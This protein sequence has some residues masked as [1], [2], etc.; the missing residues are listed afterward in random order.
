VFSSPFI[1]FYR[2]WCQVSAGKNKSGDLLKADAGYRC[3]GGYILLLMPARVAV[4]TSHITG[5]DRTSSRE[6]Y[7]SYTL[8]L[9]APLSRHPEGFEGEK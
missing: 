4:I 1:R 5:C 3:P 2:R 6:D 7:I 8:E 9:G